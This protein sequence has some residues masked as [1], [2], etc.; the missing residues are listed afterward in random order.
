MDVSALVSLLAPFLPFLIKAGE[1]AS[2]EIGQ[3]FGND[4]WNKAK[5][6]WEKLQTKVSNKPS[7]KEAVEDV[8]NQPDNYDFQAVLRVQLTKLLEQEPEL[9]KQIQRLMENDSSAP[10]P[11]TQINQ[12]VTGNENKTVGQARDV[13]M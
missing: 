1:K 3:K 7:C 12:N 4:A 13:T 9:A 5:G 11:R 10:S 6:I 8:A 2:E